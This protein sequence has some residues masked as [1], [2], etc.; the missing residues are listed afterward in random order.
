[1]NWAF[2]ALPVKKK[3][4]GL[5]DL[6]SVERGSPVSSLIRLPRFLTKAI[7]LGPST[8]MVSIASV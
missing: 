4:G 5:G 2:L 6:E 1:M 7:D 8:P 3:D